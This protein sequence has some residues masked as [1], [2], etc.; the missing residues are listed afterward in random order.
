MTQPKI[1]RY[2]CITNLQNASKCS[3]LKIVQHHI[4]HANWCLSHPI[5][6]KIPPC[7]KLRPAWTAKVSLAFGC[8]F[9]TPGNPRCCGPDLLGHFTRGWKTLYRLSHYYP[10]YRVPL[11]RS[12]HLHLLQWLC[13]SVEVVGGKHLF[14]EHV[15]PKCQEHDQHLRAL[16]PCDRAE[17][18]QESERSVA[19]KGPALASVFGGFRVS[20][21]S[22][23]YVE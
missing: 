23:T 20:T 14:E 15:L 18:L 10:S 8:P 4:I 12:L 11:M 16:S 19:A 21:I 1:E 9:Q 5:H 6:L 13:E 3:V 7:F 2:V 17:R 22:Q